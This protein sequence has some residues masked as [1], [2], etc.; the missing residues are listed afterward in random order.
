MTGVQ[1]CA[2]PIYSNDQIIRERILDPRKRVI[3]RVSTQNKEKWIDPTET[4]A[5]SSY[6]S[7]PY[8]DWPELNNVKI[9]HVYR[10]PIKV[11]RSFILDFG[12]FSKNK[13]NKQNPFNE[14][15][16]EEKI[17]SFLPELSYIR[18]QEERF[19]YFYFKTEMVGNF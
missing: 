11:A 12:Y 3:S 8:L 16:F 4:I 14:L 2:L 15:G 6:L 1:T 17:W 5:E 10:N 13:P 19:C 9:I 18:T 7:V